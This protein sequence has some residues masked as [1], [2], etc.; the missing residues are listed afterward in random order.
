MEHMNISTARVGLNRLIEG[1]RGQLGKPVYVGPYGTPEAVIS[2]LGVWRRLLGAV[3]ALWDTQTAVI[4]AGRLADPGGPAPMTLGA[5]ALL[6]GCERPPVPVLRSRGVPR[7]AADLAV[8]PAALKDLRELAATS[9]P[10][11]SVAVVRALAEVLQGRA[12]LTDSQCGHGAAYVVVDVDGLHAAI[13]T[14]RRVSRP[15]GRR[16]NG[17]NETVELIAVDC[18]TW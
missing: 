10:A 2:P 13:V 17:G 6:V 4:R 16:G 18:V 3:A 8:W 7:G 15:S 9:T 11:T 14:A 5:L 1:W 12:T